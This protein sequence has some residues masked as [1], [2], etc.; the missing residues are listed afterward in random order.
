MNLFFRKY[1]SGPAFVILHGL[2]GSSDNWVGIANSLKDNFEVFIPDLRNHGQSPKSDLMNYT[3]LRNDVVDFFAQNN[4]EKAIVLGHSMGG[5]IAIDFALN[6]PEKISHLVVAD[7]SP[8]PY[9]E[10]RNYK[11]IFKH[12]RFILQQLLSVNLPDF[13]E[14]KQISDLL[15]KKLYDERLVNFLLKNLK[16]DKESG[17]YWAINLDVINNELENILKGASG[18]ELANF[19][20]TSGFPVLFLKGSLS[21]YLTSDDYVFI[22]KLFPFAEIEEI[23]DAGHWLHAEQPEIFVNK[24]REFVFS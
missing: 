17:F 22:R 13:N 16:R 3:E 7:I 23:E 1:G 4:I 24:V 11:L 12:H 10:S 14:R 9:S 8:R 20:N 19:L 18:T 21:S 15:Q 2:Y 6:Y 5:R